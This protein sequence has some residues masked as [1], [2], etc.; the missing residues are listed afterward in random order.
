MNQINPILVAMALT[1]AI[2]Y[3]VPKYVT[4]PSGIKTIDDMVMGINATRAVS[5]SMMVMVGVICGGA[6]L[7]NE[8]YL[9]TPFMGEK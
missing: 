7:I 3:I 1:L 6:I 4:K 9:E 8:K 2:Y 5:M